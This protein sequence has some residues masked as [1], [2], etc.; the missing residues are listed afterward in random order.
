MENVSRRAAMALGA[1]TAA[2]LVTGAVPSAAIADEPRKER[3]VKELHGLISR[4][5][6]EATLVSVVVSFHTNDDD[7]DWDTALTISVDKAGQAIAKT[8]KP[9]FGRFPDHSDNGPFGL[10][11]LQTGVKKSEVAGTAIHVHIDPN[12]HDTWRFNM[13]V[14]LAFSDGS[15]IEGQWNGQVVDQDNRDDIRQIA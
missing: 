11:L 2:A 5:E 6:T 10:V 1:G 3:S 12:G 13:H 14:N 8:P 15:H 7:K 4:L 9:I